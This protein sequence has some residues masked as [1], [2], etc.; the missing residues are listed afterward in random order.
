MARPAAI[1]DATNLGS[2]LLLDKD[3]RVGLTATPDPASPTFDDSSWSIR[4]ATASFPDVPDEDRPPDTEGPPHRGPD[5]EPPNFSKGH[6]RPFAWFRLHIRLAPNHGPVALL[7]ELPVSTATSMY[8]ATG[9]AAYADVYANGVLIQPQGPHGDNADHFQ[10]ISRLYD[11]KVPP[12]ETN[13][14]LV[15]K[16][17]YMP[18]G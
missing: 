12:G 1:F 10:A 8:G 6:G 5:G 16:S 18:L 15:A 4:D 17:F 14:V 9:P 2:P 7:I 13:L 11:L 3:W